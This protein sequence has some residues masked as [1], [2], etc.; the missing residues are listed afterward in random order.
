MDLSCYE[1]GESVNPLSTCARDTAK[2][3]VWRGN[4]GM[5]RTTCS[6]AVKFGFAATSRD[7]L[8]AVDP[9]TSTYMESYDLLSFA[10]IYE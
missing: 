8:D 2:L 7:D 10:G 9:S 6:I 5:C 1:E 3:V 4:E